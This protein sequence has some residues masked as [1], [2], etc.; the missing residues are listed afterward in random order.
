MSLSVFDAHT[1][2]LPWHRLN[3]N[4][5]LDTKAAGQTSKGVTGV[6]SAAATTAKAQVTKTKS[7]KKAAKTKKAKATASV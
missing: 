1:D 3:N 6:A 5:S 7:A 2:I 4:I